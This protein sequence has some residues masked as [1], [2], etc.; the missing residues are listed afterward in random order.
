MIITGA[1]PLQALLHLLD[2]NLTG[3]QVG[4]SLW[5]W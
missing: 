3:D 5:E 2:M 4:T 1:T